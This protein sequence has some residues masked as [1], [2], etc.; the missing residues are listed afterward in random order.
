MNIFILSSGEAPSDKQRNLILSLTEKHAAIAAKKLRIEWPFNITIY[1]NA[2]WAIPETGEGG[3]TPSNDWVQIYLDLSENTHSS[4]KVI[5]EGMVS[6]IYHEMNHL[7]RWRTTGYGTTLEEALVSEGLA[8]VFEQEMWP[9]FSAPWLE[10]NDERME[11]LL[12]IFR[13]KKPSGNSYVHSAWFFGSDPAIPKWTGYMVGHYII[14]KALE[15]NPG[16]SLYTMMDKP[17]SEI[18]E[19][20][21]IKF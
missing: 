21:S 9:S 1:P 17:A 4:E 8:G 6:A 15:S 13:E 5:E 2:A 10:Y 19:M 11:E 16:V 3:F 20:S 12:K 18:I 7:K 14:K